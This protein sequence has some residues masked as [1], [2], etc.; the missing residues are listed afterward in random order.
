MA[1][2][3]ISKVPFGHVSNNSQL[4]SFHH[5]QTEFH[6]INGIQ[7]WTK[8]PGSQLR[9]VIFQGTKLQ[10][11]DQTLVSLF[12]VLPRNFKKLV[13]MPEEE[14]TSS[15]CKWNRKTEAGGQAA[16]L[17]KLLARGRTAWIQTWLQSL[18]TLQC[19]AV[20][21]PVLP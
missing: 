4:Q 14:Q 9:D 11:M 6:W 17:A 12:Q 8:V 7:G 5:Q 2:F 3:I 10:H 19:T 13:L 1:W 20:W 15:I 18:M 16:K 21:K